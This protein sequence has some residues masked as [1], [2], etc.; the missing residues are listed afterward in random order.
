V[1]VF[2]WSKDKNLLGKMGYFVLQD[3]NFF[4]WK[5]FCVEKDSNVLLNLWCK[6][7]GKRYR[8]AS[9]PLSCI[10]IALSHLWNLNV[11]QNSG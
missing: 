10:R 5:G 4:N 2:S 7:K 6:R 8:L 11:S 3:G 1:L 9:V